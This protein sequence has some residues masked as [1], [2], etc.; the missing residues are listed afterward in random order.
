PLCEL[1]PEPL[2]ARLAPESGQ[3]RM[4]ATLIA[5]LQ[6]PVDLAETWA[7][8][9][10][11][12]GGRVGICFALGYRDVEYAAFGVDPAK[13]AAALGAVGG[14]PPGGGGEGGGGAG[15]GGGLP[16]P[17]APPPGGAGPAGPPR[18]SGS[19]PTPTPLSSGPPA[20][21]CR[22]TSTRTPGS[23]PCPARPGCTA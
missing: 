18:R 2:I 12:T 21:A 6:N 9:D 10:V 23:R 7:S 20:G 4:V 16:R 22:G 19:P 8:L 13:R 17:A 11:I 15:G 1:Q 5:P 3:M 14:G